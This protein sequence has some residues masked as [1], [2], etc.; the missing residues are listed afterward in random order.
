MRQ[1]NNRVVSIGWF[2]LAK[3]RVAVAEWATV[4]EAEAGSAGE[5]PA[6]EYPTETHSDESGEAEKPPRFLNL[7][8]HRNR[9]P[10]ASQNSPR[11]ES[12]LGQSPPRR[13]FAVRTL[14]AND[15]PT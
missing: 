6:K 4:G 7:L 11:P 15:N 12:Q 10:D 8:N 13:A 5:Q 9:F 14:P 2:S 3:G 1:L